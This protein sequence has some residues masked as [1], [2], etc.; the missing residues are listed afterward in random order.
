[1]TATGAALVAALVGAG[2]AAGAALT[3]RPKSPKIPAAPKIPEPIKAD[4]SAEEA[5]LARQRASLEA[6]R[7]G[8]QAL[9]IER[10]KA[11]LSLRSDVAGLRL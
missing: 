4:T 10:P 6:R 8:R 9:V 11:G 2:A 1:M 3:P 7:R 5:R